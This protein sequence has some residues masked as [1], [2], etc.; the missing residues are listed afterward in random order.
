VGYIEGRS[1]AKNQLD[2]SSRF[3]K[4]PAAAAAD[5]Q[6]DRHMT[7]PYTALAQ[8]RAVKMFQ[9]HELF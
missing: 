6:T 8:R 2:T 4:I 7:T 5:G 3:D 1:L 9:R